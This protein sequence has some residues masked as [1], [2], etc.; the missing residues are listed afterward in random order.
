VKRKAVVLLSGGLD[1]A[2]TLFYARKKG[3]EC[4]CLTFDYGQR[5]IKETS[6]AR[7]LARRAGAGIKVMKL[8]LPWRGSSLTDRT[9]SVP[10]GRTAKEIKAGGIPST[11]VPG[12]NTI[13][14]SL[15]VSYAEAIGADIVFIGAHVQDSSGYPDCRK[16]YLRA[17]NDVIRSGTK[18]GLEGRLKLGYPLIEKDKAGI[19]RLGQNLGVPF[20]LTWSCYKG[21]KKPCGESDSCVLRARGFE[22]AG[23]KD[24]LYA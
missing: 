17:F 19:I 11:Y 13:F 20:E 7:M 23:I 14:L 22:E 16:G 18:R 10:S 15:A 1:S 2:V 24:P 12:R 6:C 3:Y 8:D 9:L 5:H 21:G 4:H